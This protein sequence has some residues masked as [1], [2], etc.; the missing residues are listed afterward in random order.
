MALQV[1]EIIL[2]RSLGSDYSD[3]KPDRDMDMVIKYIL[4]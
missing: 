3:L 4:S 1:A 2:S